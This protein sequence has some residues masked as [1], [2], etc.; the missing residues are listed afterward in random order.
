MSGKVAAAAPRVPLSQKLLDA[1]QDGR[2]VTAVSV[3]KLPKAARADYKDGAK[4][5]D[6]VQAS[7]F[8]FG[9]DTFFVVQKSAEDAFDVYDFYSK[10]GKSAGSQE[11]D[12]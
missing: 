1:L 8:Q 7:K 3:G 5:Y 4:Q 9:K 12:M 10:S 11:V 2:K 6:G